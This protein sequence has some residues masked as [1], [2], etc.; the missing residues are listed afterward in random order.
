MLRARS[1]YL[2]GVAVAMGIGVTLRAWFHVGFVGGFPQDDGIYITLARLLANHVDILERYHDLPPTYLANPAEAFA[3]R[4]ALVYPLSWSFRVF[5]EGDGPAILIGIVCAALSIAVIAEIAKTAISPRAG[6]AAALLLALLPYDIILTTRVLSD[7][8]LR[9]FVALACLFALRGW[10]TGSGPAFAWTG[11]MLG[12][13]YLTK[14][15]GLA[16][17]A[18]FGI[19]LAIRCLKRRSTRP[20]MFH[21][22]GFSSVV[23]VETVWYWWRT[24]QLFLHYR[25]VYSST[26]S[27]LKFEP[28]SVADIGPY[29]RVLWDGEFIWYA[30]I[31][32]GL[33]AVGYH[34]LA[35][36]GLQGWLWLA[37]LIRAV[38]SRAAGGRVLAGLAVGLYLFLEFFPLNVA[39]ADGRLQ[40]ALVYRQWRFASFLT[41]AWIPLGGGVL[42]AAWE[43]STAAAAVVL[44]VCAISGWPALVRNYEVLRGSQADMRSTAAFIQHRPERIYTDRFAVSIL[45]Y[46]MGSAEAAKQVRDIS[47]LGGALPAQGDLVIIGGSRGIELL[48]EVWERD[49]PAWCPS[50]PEAPDSSLPGWRVLLRIP[51]RHDMTRVHDL[52]ILQHLGS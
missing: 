5:G 26:L 42:A 29:G 39:V 10:M 49:L 32:L 34:S 48:S 27:K 16:L 35:G 15:S 8:P 21:A 12:F 22:L 47:A 43:R 30:P 40:Y 31:V 28:F 33:T 7:G 14:I 17:F 38:R 44:A 24:G 37:G 50:T 1:R 2:L 4:V 25:I 13:A 20:L 3:F 23:L 52:L 18:S 46:Y 36:F 51:G 19:A 11:A 45:Q 9:L 41:P 6:V